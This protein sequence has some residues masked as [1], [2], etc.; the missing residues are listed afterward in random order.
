M[1][2]RH[3]RMI[4]EVARQGNLTRAAECLFLSQSAL[5]H[6]LREIEDY[7]KTQIFIRQKKQML[8]TEAGRLI[9][10]SSE[11]ILEELDRTKSK[12][13]MVTEK[14]AGEIRI[15]TECYTSYHWLSGFLREFRELYPKVEIHIVPDAT[16]NSKQCLLDNKIDIGIIEDNVNPK[17][18]YVRLFGDEFVAVVPP[19]HPWAS[20]KWVSP[21][22]FYNQTY[23]MYN[24]PDEVSTVFKLLFQK[25]EPRKVYKIGL[26]EAIIEMVTAGIGVTV[27]PHW[28]ARPYIDSG[29]LVAIPVTR[30]GIKRVWY[31]ASLKNKQLPPYMNAFMKN[32]AKHLKQSEELA[33]LEYN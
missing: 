27:I 22:L 20:L 17:L 28:V 21:E 12:V 6:Q 9:L 2:I 15:S 13:Q 19:D 25:G 33:M 14:D 29:E 8:L 11:R 18:N 23:I 10:E 7:F 16:Y 24:I 4:K 32:L 5:S 30:R 3:L 1:E 26:T 31:A